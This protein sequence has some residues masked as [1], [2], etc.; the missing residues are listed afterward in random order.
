V[1]V[2]E[3]SQVIG[4]EI[5]CTS[6]VPAGQH[7]K[8]GEEVAQTLGG[9]NGV[10]LANHGVVSCGRSLEEALLA[11]QVVERAAQIRLLT[12]II[13]K[14]IPIPSEFVRSERERWLYKYGSAADG[15]VKEHD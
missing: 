8:L 9:S 3:Q 13:G 6:Y 2:E 10:L 5:R 4:D 7:K 1:V 15:S 11:C 14:A 12:N